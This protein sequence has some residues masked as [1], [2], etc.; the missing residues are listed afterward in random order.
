MCNC[1][2]ISKKNPIQL[3]IGEYWFLVGGYPLVAKGVGSYMKKLHYR[4]SNVN[5]LGT[6]NKLI[7]Y[8]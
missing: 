2:E 1:H 5:N 7:R 6:Y 8:V 4:Y 3:C